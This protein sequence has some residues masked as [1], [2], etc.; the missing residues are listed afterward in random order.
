MN[1]IIKLHIM[2]ILL[3]VVVTVL[4]YVVIAVQLLHVYLEMRLFDLLS[5][6]LS[7]IVVFFFFNSASLLV[8]L[9][10]QRLQRAS[11]RIFDTVCSNVKQHY[12]DHHLI[13]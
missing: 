6:S 3:L 13:T 7:L 9:I 11:Y 5:T 10:L 1:E 12:F 8:F 2:S 4:K